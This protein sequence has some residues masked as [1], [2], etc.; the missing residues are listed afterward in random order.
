M[1]D[2]FNFKESLKVID[3]MIAQA[4]YRSHPAEGFVTLFWGFLTMSAALLHWYLS[5]VKGLPYAPAAWMLMIVGAIVTTIANR[6]VKREKPV[7]TYID[8]LIGQIWLAFMASFTVLFFALAPAHSLFLP[9]VILLY[10]SVQWVHGWLLK[11][12]PYK[13]GA[14]TFW[15]ASSM[16]FHLPQEQQLLILA[17]AVVVGF[18]VPGYLLH[19]KSLIQH[20]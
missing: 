20:V 6:K 3:K 16:A 13:V 7:K 17:A 18:M 9:T 12:T 5:V 15:L 1:E 4:K 19:K 8:V 2:E 11:F 10:G 14:V